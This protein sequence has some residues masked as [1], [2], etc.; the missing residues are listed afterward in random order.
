MHSSAAP[1]SPPL[2]G[3][4][5]LAG[6]SSTAPPRSRASPR[7]AVCFTGGKDSTLVVH[8]LLHAPHLLA[9]A[10]AIDTHPSSSPASPPPGFPFPCTPPPPTT[11]TTASHA[12]LV[13]HLITFHDALAASRDFLSHPVH[14]IRR[15]AQA[16][17]LPHQVVAVAGPDY[18]GSYAAAV[19]AL[20]VDVLVTGDLVDADRGFMANVCTRAGVRLWCPLWGADRQMVWDLVHDLGLVPV[21]TC[22]HV[23]RFIH[24]WS[25]VDDEAEVDGACSPPPPDALPPPSSDGDDDSDDDEHG[26]SSTA[27]YAAA[28]ARAHERVGHVLDRA[29]VRAWLLPAVEADALDLGGENGEYHTMVRSAPLFRHGAVTLVGQA[30]SV[31]VP[32][33]EFVYLD[34]DH[35]A[36]EM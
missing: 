20:D 4:P 33:N 29:A 19:A 3:L 10:L 9:T 30:R 31:G 8:L 6:C 12:A 25:A 17:G 27:E 32:G 24:A 2:P 22:V 13:P 28:L 23:P 36:P 14:A 11:T 34:V 5:S 15:Q 26:A 7:L 21:L 16:M 35:D 1:P 18:V